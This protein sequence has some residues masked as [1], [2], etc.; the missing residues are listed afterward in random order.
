MLILGEEQVGKYALHRLNNSN[1]IVQTV[2]GAGLPIQI[3]D[4]N[5][6][7]EILSDGEIPF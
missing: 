1:A 2:E 4:L 5:D 7:E 3:G 6:F